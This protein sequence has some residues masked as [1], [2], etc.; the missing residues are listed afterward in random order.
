MVPPV[1]LQFCSGSER[2]VAVV[3]LEGPLACVNQSV[4]HQCV[5]AKESLPAVLTWETQPFVVEV[6]VFQKAPPGSEGLPA[7]GA[8]EGWR[9]FLSDGFAGVMHSLYVPRQRDAVPEFLAALPAKEWIRFCVFLL[10]LYE[11]RVRSESFT[12]V[13]ALKWLVTGVFPFVP[14]KTLQT[15]K[16]C[17][18]VGAGVRLGGVMGVDI[19]LMKGLK[20]GE[21][22]FTAVTLKRR[23]GF[24]V[25]CQCF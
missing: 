3:A 1:D 14:D 8:G 15:G 23:V 20:H 24:F 25:H 16:R 11:I 10:V 7:L 5:L 4:P 18:T 9:G 6:V 22:L 19:V 2:L 13:R 17:L 21:I 12:A